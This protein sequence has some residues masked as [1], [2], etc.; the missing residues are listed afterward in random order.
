[1][2]PTL[3]KLTIGLT[4]LVSSVV[5]TPLLTDSGDSGVL[6]AIVQVIIAIA[7]L[8]GLLRKRKK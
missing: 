1:M 5:T 7:T 3:E 2:K 6:N 4:G 8:A